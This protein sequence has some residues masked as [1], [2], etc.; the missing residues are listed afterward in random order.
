MHENN[1]KFVT[2][3]PASVGNVGELIELGTSG[4]KSLEALGDGYGYFEDSMDLSGVNLR[5]IAI[6]SKKGATRSEKTLKRKILRES[7]AQTKSYKKL[8]KQEFACEEDT[9]RAIEIFQSKNRWLELKHSYV[10]GMAVWSKPGRPADNEYP[11]DFNYQVE[12]RVAMSVDT[13]ERALRKKGWFVLVTNQL[14]RETWPAERLLEVYKNQGV[15][16]RGFRF[17]KSP[18][19]LSDRLFIKTPR[20]IEAL[21]MI[22]TLCLLVYSALEHK[23]RET[24]KTE[25]AFWPD[26]L[27]KLTTRPT[28]RWVFSCFHGIHEL[29][30]GGQRLVLNLKREHQR[31]LEILGPPYLPYYELNSAYVP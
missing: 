5:L 17:L 9:E 12:G 10:G 11:E 15:V 19:F 30:L 25:E 29:L 1:V 16:E 22:M 3:V 6:R 24:M 21:L 28:A 7:L 8:K 13:Y 31:L 20:R 26:Q 27:K 23:I 2:R 18:K 4:K 14:D